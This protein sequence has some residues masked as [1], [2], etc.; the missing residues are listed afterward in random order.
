MSSEVVNRKIAIDSSDSRQYVAKRTFVG[1]WNG[2]RGMLKVMLVVNL[3]DR[4][5][6]RPP[7]HLNGIGQ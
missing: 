7:R 4:G 1:A 3:V 2:L 5:D 6:V